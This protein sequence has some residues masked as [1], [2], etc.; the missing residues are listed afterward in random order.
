[1]LE[2][3]NRRS[4]V[5]S[6]IRSSYALSKNNGNLL[7]VFFK[8][9]DFYESQ[10]SIV[11][12]VLKDKWLSQFSPH[13]RYRR[14]FLKSIINHAD[15]LNAEVNEEILNEYLSLISQVSDEN[16]QKYF[17]VIFQNVNIFL[18]L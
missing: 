2:L 4:Q 7:E 9:N 8:E 1:M 10:N 17:M 14:N 3:C 6:Q 5:L 12:F 16:E 15:K 13:L 11:Q 18:V